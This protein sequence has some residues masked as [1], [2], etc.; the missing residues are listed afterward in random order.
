M[1]D[2]DGTEAAARA[3]QD[4]L[5]ALRNAPVHKIPPKRAQA[6]EKMP[7]RAQKAP[8]TCTALGETL[9]EGCREIPLQELIPLFDERMYLAIWGIPYGKADMT[10]PA[11]AETLREARATLDRMVRR[12]EVRVTLSTRFLYGRH[13]VEDGLDWID[14]YAK[15]GENSETAPNI[16]LQSGHGT[17]NDK[18]RPDG[19]EESADDGENAETLRRVCTLP[20]LRDAQGRCLADWL[21]QS[22]GKP[23]K[24]GGKGDGETDGM[25]GRFGVFAIAVHPTLKHPAGCDCPACGGLVERTIRLTLAE[26]A[27][28]WFE[29]Q[30]R[31]TF[32]DASA[33]RLIKPAVG[34]AA[35]PDHTLKKD[36]L[37]LLDNPGI[38]L[39]DSYAMIQDASICAFV[40]AARQPA[41]NGPEA[42]APDAGAAMPDIR[43]IS[44]ETA[45]KYA[46][47][48][49]FS[50]GQSAQFL[51]N[52]L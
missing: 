45:R 11:V 24:E 8:E 44:G 51:G 12:K 41:G 47:A 37:G 35:C 36:V 31:Q 49:G 29:A 17:R 28:E 43:R 33:V 9:P 18:T 6:P 34:Y 52:L 4:R 15:Q 48:R 23:Q 26:A 3:E 46:L 19:A 32:T 40:F 10:D 1:I 2:R 14:G 42:P 38:T 13:R 16:L 50:A 39:T 21:P 25:S 27:S 22:T 20:M 30:L 7:P 5:R